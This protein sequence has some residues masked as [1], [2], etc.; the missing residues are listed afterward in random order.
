[1]TIWSDL[2]E[3]ERKTCYSNN[4]KPDKTLTVNLIKK[5]PVWEAKGRLLDDW[6]Q[7]VLPEIINIVNQTY[8]SDQFFPKKRDRQSCPLP[9]WT[10]HI[11]KSKSSP[12]ELIPTIFALHKDPEI[13]RKASKLIETLK[14]RGATLHLQDYQIAYATKTIKLHVSEDES[15]SPRLD[16]MHPIAQRVGSPSN[17]AS[18]PSLCCAKVLIRNHNT[19]SA[20]TEETWTQSTIG[21]CVFIDSLRF[22]LTTAHGFCVR[23]PASTHGWEDDNS[24][25]D[26]ALESAAEDNSSNHASPNQD[27]TLTHQVFASQCDP[28][29]AIDP[30]TLLLPAQH[31]SPTSIINGSNEA[32]VDSSEK[33]KVICNIEYDWALVPVLNPLHGTSNELTLEEGGSLKV[34]GI[35]AGPTSMK[36]VIG[37]AV[38]PKAWFDFD[39]I[40]CALSLP[41]SDRIHVVWRLSQRTGRFTPERL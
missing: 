20:S 11:V 27:R 35:T 34:R 40:T 3:S 22:G 19:A 4:A 10:L 41:H 25:D 6:N 28:G 29:T 9:V 13:A 21:A 36:V 37:S 30:E 15:E 18:L 5:I 7:N 16:S 2:T 38:E 8:Y 12:P 1:M 14:N 24:N 32:E 33:S 31:P 23:S 39:G 17:E 26:D